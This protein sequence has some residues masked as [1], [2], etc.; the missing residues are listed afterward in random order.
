MKI[1]LLAAASSIHTVRWANSLSRAG[2]DIVLVSQHAPLRNLDP[3]V[4]V[5]RLPYSGEVG[6]FL[7]A[8]ALRSIL[9]EE[10]PD[11]MNAHYASGYGTTA[12]MAHF[13]PYI[14]SVWGSD[15]YDFAGKSPLH[16]WL[17]KRNLLA[18]DQIAST[19]YAMAD[20]ARLVAPLGDIE[21]TPF[22]VDTRL[23]TPREEDD[24]TSHG[25]IVIGTVK[26]MAAHYGVDI[27]IDSVALLVEELNHSNP[28]T[29]KRVRLRLVGHGP[30]M[31]ELKTRAHNL[32]IS[33]IVE[34]VGQVPH[35]AV[36]EHLRQFD[37]YAA[38]SRRESF[39]VA[40]IEAGACGLPVV[41]SDVGGLPEVVVGG[42]TGF[43]VPPESPREAAKALRQLVLDPALRRQMGAA[44]RARA[45]ACYEWRD[46]VDTMVA[47]YQKV[48]ASNSHKSVA[49]VVGERGHS[50]PARSLPR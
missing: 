49:G 10:R 17:S 38:L 41:V 29:A 11:L 4:K 23:F 46:N 16:R 12:R 42:E 40:I 19:S 8:G 36:P 13:H 45:V 5:K 47:L 43:V 30:Q 3:A 7:N 18:A 15:V 35:E 6:Y 31:N 28:E 20:Q 33:G 32:G 44:G 50:L 25:T 22:G 37:I 21:I 27:L 24:S 26:G 9:A 1:L 34:F 39:G 2:V 14:L 48:L